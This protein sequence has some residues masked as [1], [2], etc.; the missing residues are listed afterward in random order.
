MALEVL[1]AILEA[2]FYGELRT[3]QQ[4]GYIVSSG[5]KQ[6]R[7]VRSLV[8]T[9]QSGFADAVYLTERVFAFL[10]AFLPTLEALRSAKRALCGP[11]KS[12]ALG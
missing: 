3:K 2:P 11:E 12:P 5:V 9:V 10:N 1:A 8:F 6:Q 4:L 7:E